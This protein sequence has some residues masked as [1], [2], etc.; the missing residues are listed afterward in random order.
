MKQKKKKEETESV[1]EIK[2]FQRNPVCPLAPLFSFQL[3]L[4]SLMLK[5]KRSTQPDNCEPLKDLRVEL[6]RPFCVVLSK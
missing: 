2:R 4:V 6:R 3:L 1:G 5:M